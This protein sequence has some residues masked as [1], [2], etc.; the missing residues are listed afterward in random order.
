MLYCNGSVTWQQSLVTAILSASPLPAP[1]DPA[2]FTHS[3]TMTFEGQSYVAGGPTD[4]YEIDR[5]SE[6]PVFGSLR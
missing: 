3:L 5:T 4:S 1:P 6:G 2:V